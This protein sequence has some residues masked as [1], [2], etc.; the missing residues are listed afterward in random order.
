MRLRLGLG[1]DDVPVEVDMSDAAVEAAVDAVACD[2]TSEAFL[3]FFGALKDVDAA[4]L[5]LVD[6]SSPMDADSLLDESSFVA[7]FS[8]EADS[9]HDESTFAWDFSME[10]DSL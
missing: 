5:F 4:F 3:I 1:A 6:E 10:A 8:M 2:F 7:D 9:S